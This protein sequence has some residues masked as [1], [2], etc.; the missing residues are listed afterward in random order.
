MNMRLIAA[1]A[2]GPDVCGDTLRVPIMRGPMPNPAWG[3]YAHREG[4][5][6]PFTDCY[7]VVRD[8][9]WTTEVLCRVIAHEFGHLA[10]YRA[11][12][13]QEY[14]SPDGVPDY[15]HARDP[16]NLMNPFTLPP[17]PPCENGAADAAPRHGA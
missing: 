6:A 3:A 2:Y 1:Q 10:G 12:E 9:S 8:Q 13:G 15:D 11:P 17:W 7:I 5:F 16:G 14:V 4:D